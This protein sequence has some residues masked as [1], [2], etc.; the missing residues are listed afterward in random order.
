LVPF[1][2]I[3]LMRLASTIPWEYLAA[4]MRYK[5]ILA[6]ERY[7]LLWILF[8]RKYYISFVIQDGC[9]LVLALFP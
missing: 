9:F 2:L 4:I 8:K 1:E 6:S 7:L 3:L 5:I